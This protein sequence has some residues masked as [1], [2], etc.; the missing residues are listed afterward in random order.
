MTTT[1]K[2]WAM[3]DAG[4]DGKAARGFPTGPW[5]T[6]R[7]SHIAHSPSDDEK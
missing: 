2:G 6:L 5:K 7:V 1:V 3:D 4:P